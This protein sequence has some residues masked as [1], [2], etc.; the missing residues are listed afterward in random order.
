MDAAHFA[1]FWRIQGH[2]AIETTSCFWYNPQ[3]L[4]LLSVPYHRTFTPSRADC[5][6]HSRPWSLCYDPRRLR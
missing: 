5:R 4:V 6:L 2:K 3:P 1:E